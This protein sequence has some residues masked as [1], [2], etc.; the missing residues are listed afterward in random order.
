MSFILGTVKDTKS[1]SYTDPCGPTPMRAT[2]YNSA[3]TIT[4][5]LTGTDPP[6]L[7]NSIP[8][9]LRRTY[10]YVVNP[11]EVNQEKARLLEVLSAIF[12]GAIWTKEAVKKAKGDGLAFLA[13]LF[14]RAKSATSPPTST[15]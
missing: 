6:K 10:M 3:A 14:D 12:S 11:Y 4:L 8:E 5:A 13:A 7:A 1:N 2:R 15:T 9:E